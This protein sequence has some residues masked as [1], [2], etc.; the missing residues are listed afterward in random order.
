M[1][2]MRQRKGR[3]AARSVA[4]QAGGARGPQAD[5]VVKDGIASVK[6]LLSGEL[7]DLALS[8]VAGLNCSTALWEQ[9]HLAP[10]PA[11]ILRDCLIIP[12]ATRGSAMPLNPEASPQDIWWQIRLGDDLLEHGHFPDHEEWYRSHANKE[13]FR[14]S[15]PHAAVSSRGAVL[16]CRGRSCS[17]SYTSGHREF[18]NHWW[19]ASALFS[20]V[21]RSSHSPA[22]ARGAKRPARPRPSLACAAAA[23]P[24]SR[25]WSA[26]ACSSAQSSSACC[27][28]C[29]PARPSDGPSQRS[30]SRCAA[31][32]P[33]LAPAT[34]S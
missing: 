9:A 4:E 22:L 17:R 14:P 24:G 3:Q 21:H 5:D 1:A 33:A 29:Y 23:L 12:D 2:E 27:S 6:T 19:I 26:C 18:H 34:H 20:V 32:H 7:P 16:M 8:I 13:L 28:P 30:A 31:A 10:A 11:P 25:G 15:L